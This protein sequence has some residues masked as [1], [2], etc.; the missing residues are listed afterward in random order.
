MKIHVIYERI[1]P[2]VRKHDRQCEK[3]AS[4]RKAKQKKDHQRVEEGQR[5]IPIHEPPM[6]ERVIHE[7]VRRRS[8]MQQDSYVYKRAEGECESV[9]GERELNAR[10]IGS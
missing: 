3:Q 2:H 9:P 4:S 6:Q 7:R 8:K 10:W 5:V 1:D